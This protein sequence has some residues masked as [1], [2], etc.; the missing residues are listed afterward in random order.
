[1]KRKLISLPAFLT[2]F[3]IGVV[4]FY[5]LYLYLASN[6]ALFSSVQV[7]DDKQACHSSRLFPGK[8][9]EVSKL[10]AEKSGYFPSE[11]NDGKSRDKEAL[12]NDFY[13]VHL[14]AMREEP[15]IRYHGSAK[16]VYRF[17]WLRSFDHPIVIR[18]EKDQ[19]GATLFIK[20]TDSKSG[21][22][23]GNVIDDR[24]VA[25]TEEEWCIFSSILEEVNFWNESLMAA[26]NMG[27]DGSLWLL[28]GLR[29]NRYHAVD[30]WSPKD[31]PE[32][33]VRD[34]CIYLLQRSKVDI[35]FLGND[36]Y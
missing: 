33:G 29:E 6:E 20:E 8:S 30:R 18:V 35:D 19:D 36:I 2:T 25:L 15:L 34:A 31:R 17:L 4:S 1:M 23:P 10:R 12:V 3:T 21:Y 26:D 32:D 9:R 13:A 24:R 14:R 22:N 28:E 11:A 16:E 7:D 27:R 5:F